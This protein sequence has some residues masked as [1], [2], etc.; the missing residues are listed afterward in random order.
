MAARPQPHDSLESPLLPGVPFIL[1]VAG[2]LVFLA[3]SI[4]SLWGIF[5][6]AVPNRTPA[7][8]QQPPQPRL[9]ANPPAE[10]DAILSAQRAKLSGYQWIDREKGIVSI[11]IDRAMQI[12]IARGIDAYAP[13]PGAPPAPKPDIPEI[14][15][16]IRNEQ[17]N[18]SAPSQAAQPVRPDQRAS[19]Q[20]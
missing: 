11:P 12:I 13:I 8:A 6:S 2:V 17:S 19:P 1:L 16:K 5:V 10:L 14:L 20:P 3:V 7:P 15:G 4:G 18:P 9:L